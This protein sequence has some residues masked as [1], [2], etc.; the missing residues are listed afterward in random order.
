MSQA[1]VFVTGSSSGFGFLIAKSLIEQGYTVIATMRDLAGKNADQAKALKAAA[2]GTLHL[3]ELDVTSDESV[4]KAVEQALKLTGK[5]DVLVNNAGIG[6]GGYTEA[7]STEQ[8]QQIFDVNVFGIQRVMRALLP[9]MR[10]QHSGLIINISS[11]QGRVVIPFAGAYTASKYA[12]EGLTE[13]YRYELSQAGVDVVSVE[14]GGFMTGYWSKL[15]PPADSARA[16]DYPDMTP[17]GFWKGVVGMLQGENAPNPQAVADAVI[18]LIETPAGQ[19]PLRTVVD[20]LTG[21]QAHAT[22]NQ[23]TDQVQQ[24]LLTAFGMGDRISVKSS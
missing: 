14:P 18:R 24:Q 9:A 3:L 22:I 4:K 19:R 15:I 12:L 21:G 20:P 8:F 10:K 11:T 16:T 7:F 17:D 5:I 23:T 13:T 2:K 6:G 1:V